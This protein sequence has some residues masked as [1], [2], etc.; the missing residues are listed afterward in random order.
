MD[1]YCTEFNYTVL[2]C[3]KP[4]LDGI[5]RQQPGNQLTNYWLLT[6]QQL[7]QLQRSPV[8]FGLP[9]RVF[10]NLQYS[11]KAARHPV[12]DKVAPVL[13]SSLVSIHAYG[14]HHLLTLPRGYGPSATELNLGTAVLNCRA[15]VSVLLAP[16]CT[17]SIVL[18]CT[19]CKGKPVHAVCMYCADMSRNRA[20]ALL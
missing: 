7:S 2:L 8:S 5:F 12:F 15:P 4:K 6:P 16:C 13:C 14:L 17:Y 20:D 10:G 3:N 19:C 11:C 1:F 9:W 18:L